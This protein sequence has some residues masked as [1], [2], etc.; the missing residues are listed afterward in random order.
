MKPNSGPAIRPQDF[1]TIRASVIRQVLRLIDE[2]DGNADQLLRGQE[3]RRTEVDDPYALVSMSR[4]LAIF[5]QAAVSLDDAVLGA[6][7][8]TRAKPADLGPLGLLFATAPSIRAGLSHTIRYLAVLQNGT[9]SGIVEENDVLLYR[10]KVDYQ[11][12][13]PRRQDAEY[14]LACTCQLIRDCFS[15][16]W[17]PIEVQFEHSP[18]QDVTGLRRI[19]RAPVV[20]NQPINCVVIDRKDAD[21]QYREED[22]GL[23]AVLE[24]HISDLLANGETDV[25]LRSR[26]RK[27]VSIYLGHKPIT[28]EL[29]ADELGVTKRTLQRH[30]AAEGTSL[31]EL[32][33]QHRCKI[34][35]RY[36]S[37]GVHRGRVAHLLGY[38]DATAFWR[39]YK[40]WSASR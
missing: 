16:R 29:V 35:Q 11:S 24:R 1:S 30:L 37:E 34:A 25:D 20:F 10:Y 4:Y 40:S 23:A 3:I 32:V 14:T 2:A 6:R 21:R 13:W 19:F 39:S 33:N 5:E 28:V 22:R 15:N 31:R 8:G 38:A 26:A 36:L 7:L 18:S 27:V 12:L 17:N 9:T